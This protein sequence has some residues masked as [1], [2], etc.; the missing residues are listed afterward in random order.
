LLVCLQ[1]DR[2]G[3][4]GHL[5]GGELWGGHHEQLRGRDEL[6]DRDRDVARA[7]GQVHEQHVE[8]APEHVGK[9]LLKRA[10]QHRPAPHDRG[11]PR[12][13]HPDR[14]DPHV[15]RHRWHDHLLDLGRLAGDP[16]HPGHREAVDVGV[17]HADR[18]AAGGQ[19]DGD[20]HRDGGLAHPAL[21]GRDG[22]DTGARAGLRE[23]DLV[24]RRVAAQLLAQLRPLCVT[25][26]V[27]LDVD[28]GD[29]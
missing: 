23:R 19:R 20:V 25:H 3:P 7:R 13:E 18:Q 14:D 27:E 22:V 21:A 10:V 28:G 24:H 5:A 1:R 2:A 11:V 9:E 8:I 26:H 12:G 17:Q 29:A 4:L 6:G 16:E 15:V